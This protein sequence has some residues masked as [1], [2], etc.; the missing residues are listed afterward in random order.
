MKTALIN[1]TSTSLLSVLVLLSANS[2]AQTGGIPSLKTAFKGH[3]YVGVAI[4]TSVATGKANPFF[5]RSQALVD[6]D[7]ALVKQQFNQ[8]SPENDL[9]WASIQPQP[10]PN[11][12]NFG[13]ADAYVA[14]GLKNH[15][16]IV[17]HTLVWHGQ[18]PNWV[19]AGPDK[20]AGATAA[21]T[22]IT[23][24]HVNEPPPAPR[25][26]GRFFGF[27][28]PFATRDQLLRRMREH[29]DTV[30]GR[31]KGK[32]KIW[33]VVNECVS[34][35]GPNILRN[36]LWRQ[37]IGPDFVAKAFEYAHEADPAA[38]LR[39]NDY[40]L[41]NPVKRHKFMALVKHL[42]AE[43]V[44]VM[45]IGTQTHVSVSYPSYAQEDQELTDLET[46]GLPIHITEL[47][48]NGAAAG[49][50]NT[51]A[52][53]ANNAGTTKGGLVDNA[54]RLLANQYANLF[55]VF[56]KHKL[57]KLVTFWDVNDAVSW[58]AA[59]KPLLFDGNDQ[60]KPA[61]YSVIRVAKEYNRS[62]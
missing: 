36:S 47:D 2:A 10:G 53:V 38:I 16:L 34:D 57:V 49:Q 60:P 59:G 39:L 29:I 11:G 51:G 12:Y 42:L 37:I 43:K 8:I 48:V 31:Y 6:K 25:G 1:H 28:G 32:I 61:F 3:F 15:M 52:D 22:P 41:E 54:N 45:A 30:V 35:G 24:N 21:G 18:T 14:F 7:I 56:M 58:R 44:P 20:V 46:L 62:K 27:T 5:R 9:K 17:G 33:D 4:N 23:P 19:F 26:F 13:P 50:R 40:G 55:R